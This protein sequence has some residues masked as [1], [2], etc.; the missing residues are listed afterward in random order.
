M[1]NKTSWPVTPALEKAGNPSNP[2]GCVVLDPAFVG[3]HDII[4]ICVF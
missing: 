4:N 1:T 2:R 3:I